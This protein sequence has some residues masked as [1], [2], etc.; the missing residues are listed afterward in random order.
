MSIFD[1]FLGAKDARIEVA[2]PVAVSALGAAVPAFEGRDVDA[3]LLRARLA[4]LC[5]DAGTEPMDP[6]AFDAGARELPP[7]GW[8]RLGVITAALDRVELRAAVGAAAKRRGAGEVV[9]ALV[10]TARQRARLDL[11]VLRKSPFRVEELTRAALAGA[12]VGV[13]GESREQSRL[14]L[15]R[16]DYDRLLAEAERARLAAEDRMKALKKAQE[17]DD[18]KNGPRRGKW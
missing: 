9:G 11:E 12:W 15:E 5:R 2:L 7:E 1:R 10:L 13:V 6:A 8:R 17:E 4:D 14:A 3:A 18:K 16:L